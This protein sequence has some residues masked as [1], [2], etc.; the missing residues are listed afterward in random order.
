MSQEGLDVVRQLVAVVARTFYKDEYVIA[1]DYLNRHEIARSDVLS[2]HLRVVHK[3]A[4]RIYGDLEKHKLVQRITRQDDTGNNNPY[5]RRGKHTYFFIDYRKFVDVVKWRIWRLQEQVKLRMEKEQEN[6]GYDCPDCH[7]RFKT[8][9]VLSLMDPMT[10]MFKC[11]YCDGVLVD[12]TESELALKSQREL[13]RFTAQS[14][15]ILTLLKKTDSITLPPPTPLSEIPVPDV[16]GDL[17][18]KADGKGKLGAGKELGFSRDTGLASGDTVIAFAPDLTPREAAQIREAELERK[19]R[20]NQLPAWHIWSTV[21]GVQM[22]V[23]Q[24]I[25]AEARLRHER[26]S[27]SQVL[28]ASSW[29]R[30]ERE[31]A[32]AAI[33]SLD[34]Q[35]RALADG[36]GG[37]AEVSNEQDDAKH[38]RFYARFY[39]GVAQRTGIELPHDPRDGYRLMLDQLAKD[40]ELER[41]ELEKRRLDMERYEKERK[42]AEA[43]YAAERSAAGGSSSF[44][45]RPKFFYPYKHGRSAHHRLAR[46]ATHRLFEFIDLELEPHRPAKKSAAEV[47]DVSDVEM[48]SQ[49]TADGGG[50]TNADSLDPSIDGIYALSQ[51]E[52]R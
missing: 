40:E 37:L 8:M 48:Q 39:A 5:Q 18:G 14:M 15:V 16:S 2:R 50:A 9:Q 1:L 47:P 43:A 20:Q 52:R 51:M 7:R 34:E 24:K 46:R 13:S 28:R 22:V 36:Q 30:R 3:E 29:N 45:Q 4:F 23:A 49:E 19:L 6:L 35:I 32:R 38:E 21:S 11:D 26:Y 17:D 41:A 33:R 44:R 27:E 12:N 42:E 31:R 10:G 25:T